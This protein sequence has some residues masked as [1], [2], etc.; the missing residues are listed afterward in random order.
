MGSQCTGP[1]PCPMS[2]TKPLFKILPPIIMMMIIVIRIMIIIVPTGTMINWA[3][4]K[5]HRSGTTFFKLL[6][7]ESL[8]YID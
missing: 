2:P 1:R 3:T 6:I 5:Q 7:L 8:K 4:S